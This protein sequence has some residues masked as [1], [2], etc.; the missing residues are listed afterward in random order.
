MKIV[1]RPPA[2]SIRNA[3]TGPLNE[4]LEPLGFRVMSLNSW[5]VTVVG[6]GFRQEAV[7]AV[8]GYFAGKKAEYEVKDRLVEEARTLLGSL[9]AALDNEYCKHPQAGR[10]P[11][12][13]SP[14]RIR[15]LKQLIRGRAFKRL[16]RRAYAAG[17]PLPV[18]RNFA[19]WVVNSRSSTEI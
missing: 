19:M 5:S 16:C 8:Y 6:E 12:E 18:N 2:G 15:R 13:G 9:E 4:L 7:R 10:V 17:T 3:I 11:K 1:V 14:K